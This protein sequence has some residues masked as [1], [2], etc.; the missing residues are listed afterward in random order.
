MK[1]VKIMVIGALVAFLALAWIM[2]CTGGGIY[3]NNPSSSPSASPGPTGK[4]TQ[5]LEPGKKLDTIVSGKAN[6][7]NL[8]V[9]GNSFKFPYINVTLDDKDEVYS[10]QEQIFWVEKS[11]NPSGRVYLTT[12]SRATYSQLISGLNL[13]MGFLMAR[14]KTSADLSENEDYIFVSDRQD[15]TGGAIYRFTKDK[16]GIVA[17]SQIQL[18]TG[19]QGEIPYMCFLTPWMSKGDWDD[20]EANQEIPILYVR[21]TGANTS[22]L[23]M[24]NAH[25]EEGHYPAPPVSIATDLDHP[26]HLKVFH[27]FIPSNAI[28]P[29]TGEEVQSPDNANTF[30]FVTE[31]L[32]APNG[33]VLMYNVS[34]WDDEGATF[35][36]TVIATGLQKP[37]KMTFVPDIQKYKID[38][39]GKISYGYGHSEKPAGYLYWTTF[40]GTSGQLWRARLVL[41]NDATNL[42]VEKVEV[43]AQSLRNPYDV[44]GPDDYRYTY[45]RSADDGND[46][47]HMIHTDGESYEQY[48]IMKYNTWAVYDENGSSFFHKIYVSSNRSQADGGNWYEI[49]IDKFEEEGTLK[50]GDDGIT[51]FGS[52][53]SW[54]P[55]NG[56]ID[57]YLLQAQSDE[58]YSYGKAF[59]K[60]I[61]YTGYT[62]PDGN[63]QGYIYCQQYNFDTEF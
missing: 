9:W 6:I 17:D 36:P 20:L 16:D 50:P 45:L 25:P 48:M 55:F 14:K 59:K 47:L 23:E 53:S 57:L 11:A 54:Y 51:N 22:A 37:S 13:P 42:K 34:N 35:T 32:D 49:N 19:L 8:I 43:V 40:D 7:Y 15:P 30:V 4:P 12:Y 21:N 39:D 56:V 1:K 52:E 46:E 27:H 63:T 2:G 41:N 28:D 29:N 26:H 5:V 33:R 60:D 62:Y 38:T 44:I 31:Q 10:W 58:G 24:T 3:D 61:I 18:T